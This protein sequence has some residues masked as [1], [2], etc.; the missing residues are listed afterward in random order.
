[1]PRD[2][3]AVSALLSRVEIRGGSMGEVFVEGSRALI[4]GGEVHGLTVMGGEGRSR[5]DFLSPI[6]PLSIIPP[7]S[8]CAEVRGGAINGPIRVIDSALVLVG[9]HF[10]LPFGEIR[11]SESLTSVALAGE[12][13]DG[14]PLG[15]VVE[16]IG[17]VVLL[18]EAREVPAL[19]D[20]DTPTSPPLCGSHG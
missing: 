10:N 8:S 14:S 16:P 17:G 2:P 5:R 15:I 13:A 1:M 18:V 7:T 12:L 20:S 9:R 4:R 3:P 6:L 11:G 19:P